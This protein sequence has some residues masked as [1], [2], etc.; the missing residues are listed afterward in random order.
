MPGIPHR[1]TQ[2]PSVVVKVDINAQ[3]ANLLN[4]DIER[5]K[6]A[7]FHAVIAVND[8]FVHAGAP[9]H[10]TIKQSK[11]ESQSD[12][13]F[14]WGRE[15][16]NAFETPWE[17]TVVFGHTPRPFPIQKTNMIGIDT[18]CVYDE[19]GYGKL[20]AVILPDAEFVQQESLD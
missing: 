2:L 9:P 10:Q 6:H 13:F 7:R 15:H 11:N 12:H 1:F 18:G 20:T 8:V 4:Q 16:L 14:L 3:G 19:L 17:K 5:L